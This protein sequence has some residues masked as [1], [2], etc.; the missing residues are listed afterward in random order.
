VCIASRD[1]RETC[2]KIPIEIFNAPPI[3]KPGPD[4][5]AT[6]GVPISIE[7]SGTDPDGKIVKWEWDLNGDGKFDLASET[8]G[9][10]QYTF[11]KLGTF[12]MVLRV[13][14]EDGKQATASRKVEVRKK[15]KA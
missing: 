15:W 9:K 7:G 11:A 13:T 12:P 5:H 6:L 8:S 2:R 14:S 4:L 1:G 10:F 3:C